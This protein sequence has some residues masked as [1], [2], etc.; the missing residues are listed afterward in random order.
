MSF[1]SFFYL[2]FC[3][4]S[5]Q[6]THFKM[7]SQADEE[8]KAAKNVYEGINNELKDELPGLFER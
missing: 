6:K 3:P 1:F 2:P 7:I 8:M 5:V 4:A